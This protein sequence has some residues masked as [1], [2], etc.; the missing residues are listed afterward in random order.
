MH[1]AGNPHIQTDPRNMRAVAAALAKRLAV[2]DPA[3]AAGYQQRAQ[4]FDQALGAAMDRMLA[5]AAP[6]KGVVFVSYHKAWIYLA[7]WL[8]MIEVANIEPKPGVPPGSAYIAELLD[9]I[10]SLKARMIVY[11]AYEDPNRR[12]SSPTRAICRRSCCRSPSAATMHRRTSSAS[13]RTR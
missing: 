2:V 3:H 8:G 1:P 12:N 7:N 9:K 6:L 10:P 5:Q 13:I 11:A 4:A